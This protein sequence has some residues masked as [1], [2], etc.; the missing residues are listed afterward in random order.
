MTVDQE[1]LTVLVEGRVRDFEKSMDRV[2][3]RLAKMEKEAKGSMQ[4]VERASA[5]AARSMEQDFRKA[6]QGIVASFQQVNAGLTRAMAFTGVGA[7]LGAAGIF[8][9]VQRAVQDVRDLAAEAERAGVAFEQFQELRFLA[10]NQNVSFDALTDGFKELQLRAD[11]FIATGAGPATEAF[12]RLGFGAEELAAAL[13]DPQQLFLDILSRL[14]EF[15]QAAQIRIADEVFGGTGGEQFVQ[16][17][18]LSDEELRRVLARAR[19]VGAVMDEEV[20]ARAQIVAERFEEIGNIISNRV[21]EALVDTG[22]WTL[23]VADR[24]ASWVEAL[25]AFQTALNRAGNSPIFQRLNDALADVGLLGRIEGAEILDPALEAA[26]ERAERLRAE[27]A[28]R[29]ADRFDALAGGDAADRG[30]VGSS[31]LERRAAELRA[32]AAEGAEEFERQN[33][34]VA[35]L[36]RQLAEARAQL[37]AMG[38]DGP[39]QAVRLLNAEVDGLN[40]RLAVARDRLA[41]IARGL[42]MA[43]PPAIDLMGG[44]GSSMLGGGARGDILA[45]PL[46]VGFLE[47]RLADGNEN[48]RGLTEGT[49][50]ALQATLERFPQLLVESARR[51]PETNRGAPNSKHLDGI[52]FDLVGFRNIE[53]AVEVARFLHS[54]GA[55]GFGWYNNGSLHADFRS[56]PAV[57]GPNFSSSS[58]GQTPGLWQQF[59]A[60]VMAGGPAMAGGAGSGTL[61]GGAGSDLLLDGQSGGSTPLPRARPEIE[62]ET[63]ALR[64]NTSAVEENDTARQAAA[65][66]TDAYAA[67]VLVLN[68]LLRQ[69]VITQQEYNAAIAELPQT[70]AS[71]ATATQEMGVAMADVGAAA[72]SFLQPVIGTLFSLAENSENAEQAMKRLAMQ[73]AQMVLN[74]ALFGQGPLGKLF[75]GGLLGGLLGGGGGFAAASAVPAVWAASGGYVSGP[76]TGTSDSIPARLSDGEYV[77][78]A[79]ATRRHRGLLEAINSGAAMPGFAAGGL[80]GSIPRM[81]GIPKLEVRGGDAEARVVINDQRRAGSPD[82]ARERRRGDDG[83]EEIRL[84]IRDEVERLVGEDVT[85]DGPMSRTMQATYGLRRR[86]R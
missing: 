10:R 38:D 42:E 8:R 62:A 53:E 16:F 72:Q 12:Q 70:T 52:A 61:A 40:E 73:M 75:G 65:A 43:V 56:Q 76:G 17:L 23:Q 32:A 15:D 55:R 81:P 36:E 85:G 24:L 22:F 7:G 5:R 28:N 69:G 37:E 49:A 66:G 58:L 30:V 35:I 57:W 31:A 64:E 13:E 47:S 9:E 34:L 3:R 41:E 33:E 1:R 11:E 44:A 54:I 4:G 60:A 77:V 20:S 45:R 26:I 50:R 14:R 2:N 6:N 78:N 71:A 79:R 21:N 83:M 46:D 39:E 84:T 48:I 86:T 59:A 82:I 68:D 29:A 67:R 18:S 74:A 63:A 27:R 25:G 51:T 19:E 80:V